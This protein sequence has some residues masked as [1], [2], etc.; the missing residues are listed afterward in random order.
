MYTQIN[1]QMSPP[2]AAQQTLWA[3]SHNSEHSTFSSLS[4]VKQEITNPVSTTVDGPLS[5]THEEKTES[6]VVVS[7]F[8]LWDETGVIM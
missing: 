8:A 6:L 3:F 2:P 5:Q 1:E 4:S 7:D